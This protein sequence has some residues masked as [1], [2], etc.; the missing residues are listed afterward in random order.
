MES[1]IDAGVKDETL[2]GI[3]NEIKIARGGKTKMRVHF[4]II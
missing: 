1:Y 2:T 3:T 4:H